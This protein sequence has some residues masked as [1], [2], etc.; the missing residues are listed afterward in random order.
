MLL[1]VLNDGGV[2]DENIRVL[3]ASGSHAHPPDDRFRASVGDAIDRVEILKHDPEGPMTDYGI[4]S[5][6]TPV[7]V[8]ALLDEADLVI[9][10]TAVVHHYF[11]GFGGGRKI[12]VPGLASLD[13]IAAN[14]A[15]TF[16]T[17]GDK[18]GRHPGVFSG[19]LDGNPVHEDMLEAAQM[20]LR[21]KTYFSIVSVIL[22]DKQ[23]G[24]FAAG[25][26]DLSHR[27]ACAF[28]ESSNGV[29]IEE[30]ADVVIAS[31]GGAPKDGNVI[32]SHKG[33]DNAV[34]AL[35]PGGTLL[36]AMSCFDGTGHPAIAEFAPLSLTAIRERLARDYIVY[37]QT[38]YALKE[39]AENFRIVLI[40][41]LDPELVR[42]L[43][44]EPADD[45]QAAVSMI[46]SELENAKLVYH[47]PRADITVPRGFQEP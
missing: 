13:S 38:V 27:R 9:P 1:D 39:K 26:I 16:D 47:L 31:A 2:P 12:F 22:P 32:Q 43:G 34:R 18:P 37:G 19:N 25:D 40:S 17:S 42:L 8:N 14:H 44:L 45:I 33:M 23:F 11:A 21:D 24:F 28:V 30:L 7:R 3:V 36:Y 10:S 29:D 46:G 20:V 35:K 5:R 6:G 15:L 41:G 4:T